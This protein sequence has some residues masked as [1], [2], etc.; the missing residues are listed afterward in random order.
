VIQTI[1]HHQRRHV[2]ADENGLTCPFDPQ[3]HTCLW[4]NGTDCLAT[5]E[6]ALNCPL[7]TDEDRATIR[8]ELKEMGL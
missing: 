8:A 4:S 1:I 5:M 6:K 2:L 7:N 3:G